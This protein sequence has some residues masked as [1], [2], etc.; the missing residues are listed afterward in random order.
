MENFLQKGWIFLVFSI[1]FGTFQLVVKFAKLFSKLASQ[2]SET[3][4]SKTRVPVFSA[5][6]FFFFCSSSDLPFT[7]LFLLLLLLCW[8]RSDFFVGS[9]SSFSDL[10]LQNLGSTWINCSTPALEIESQR[11][12]ML[13]YKIASKTCFLTKCFKNHVKWKISSK[14]DR[15]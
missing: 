8:I 12:E 7:V 15:T 3:Q 5:V 2:G 11:L 10:L 9:A 4:V 14:K 6:L 1:I 13:V